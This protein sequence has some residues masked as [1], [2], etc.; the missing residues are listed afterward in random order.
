MPEYI[1]LPV[2]VDDLVDEVSTAPLSGVDD[3]VQPA[4]RLVGLDAAGDDVLGE[5]GEPGA[6]PD[7]ELAVV[8]FA[9]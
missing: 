8:D 3:G 6:G 1:E 5:A 4:G 7:D 2:P 9:G